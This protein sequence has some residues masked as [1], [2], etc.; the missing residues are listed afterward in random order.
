MGVLGLFVAYEFLML[1]A[2]NRAHRQQ[3]ELPDSSWIGNIV[4][5]NVL[6]AIGILLTSRSGIDPPYR[7]LAH[8]SVLVFFLFITL[9]TLR[10][11]LRFVA[12]LDLWQRSAT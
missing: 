12:F 2:V 8:P 6:P 9:S 4:V 7:V 3:R 10:L 11:N 1:L 5:E